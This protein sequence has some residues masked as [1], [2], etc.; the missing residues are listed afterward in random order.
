LCYLIQEKASIL[1]TLKK[2]QNRPSG[3]SPGGHFLR[4]KFEKPGFQ[5]IFPKNE[6]ASILLKKH[7]VNTR[8]VA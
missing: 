5:A 4:K 2:S 1:F 7:I 8:K 3:I 6:V